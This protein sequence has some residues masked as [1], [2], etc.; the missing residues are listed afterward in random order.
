[1]QVG[2]V[3]SAVC[4]YLCTYLNSTIIYNSMLDETTDRP[5]GRALKLHISFSFS[6][7]HVRSYYYCYY[8][9]PHFLE[10]KMPSKEHM[11]ETIFICLLYW[12]YNIYMIIGGGVC[13]S[14]IP[15]DAAHHLCLL[16]RPGFPIQI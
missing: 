15:A 12:Y 16:V 14:I 6:S 5:L 3:F 7:P 10:E 8:Q 4:T 2:G 11:V 9:P 1:M 13:L